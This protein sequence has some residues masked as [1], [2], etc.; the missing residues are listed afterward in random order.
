MRRG[1]R[2]SRLDAAAPVHRRA[3][4]QRLRDLR[5]ECRTPSYRVLSSLAHCATGTLSEAASGRRLPTWET[6]RAYVTGCLRHAGRDLGLAAE[7]DRWRADWER[8][9]RAERTPYT[10]F[11]PRVP[12]PSAVPRARR[13]RR[14]RPLL[15][16]PI[17]LLVILTVAGLRVGRPVGAPPMSGLFNVLLAAPERT[18][19]VPA[20][21]DRLHALLEGDLR[22]WSAETSAVQVRIPEDT[23]PGD[24][25][26]LA[27]QQNADVVLRPVLAG[28][29]GVRSLTAVEIYLT[30]RALGGTPEYAG[31]Y[32]LGLLE[33]TGYHPGVTGDVRPAVLSYRN[34]VLSVVRGAGAYAYG[35]FAAAESHFAGA[36]DELRLV[37]DAG[38][39]PVGRATTDLLLGIARTAQD[40][41]RAVEPLE[42]AAADDP[43]AHVALGAALS[44]LAR[45]DRPSSDVAGRLD[46]ADA[47]YE[48]FLRRPPDE[49]PGL[50]DMTAHYN[51][52]RNAECQGRAGLAGAWARAGREYAEVLRLRETT[53]LTGARAREATVLAEKA[54]TAIEWLPR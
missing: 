41:A 7:L 29:D 47:H 44:A 2:E 18:G 53:R 52:G 15:F 40:P 54:R 26:T 10:P 28:D 27:D 32:R 33:P 8:A 42:R 34:A 20:A 5:A 11:A 37:G 49:G 12:A 16:L 43:R 50:L 36:G 25:G 24:L 17:V 1:R 35:D 13:G 9:A 23:S 21:A 30:G 38:E 6:T 51:L 3:F 19:A 39:R 31:V 22:A 46:D 14:T 48:R 4:A 45:C